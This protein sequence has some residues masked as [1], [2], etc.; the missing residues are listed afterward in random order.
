M[1]AL[2]KAEQEKKEA[3]KRQQMSQEASA[4]TSDT[5]DRQ[6]LDNTWEHDI[7]GT[8][9][10]PATPSAD[11]TV[12]STTAEL[13][14]EPIQTRDIEAD[15]TSEI[16][17]F[18]TAS[19]DPTLN[20]TRNEL[21]I[22]EMSADSP[23]LSEQEPPEGQQADIADLQTEDPDADLDETMLGLELQGEAEDPELF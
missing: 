2:K 11:S 12:R 16:G 6:D 10:A 9:S 22:A 21:D 20:V 7:S 4:P 19:E 18:E 5:K 23:E 13:S 8:G 1:D 3:A 14:L 17:V 15:T